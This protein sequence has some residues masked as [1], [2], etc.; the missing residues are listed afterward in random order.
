MIHHLI[1]TVCVAYIGCTPA[2]IADVAC[3]ANRDVNYEVVDND[4]QGMDRVP[5]DPKV[6]S[7]WPKACRPKEVSIP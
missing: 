2:T 3:L 5:Y 6:V 1:Y 7:H 4:P